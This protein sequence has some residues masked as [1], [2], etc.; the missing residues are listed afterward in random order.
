MSAQS[1]E[2]LTFREMHYT[3]RFTEYFVP[4]YFFL[5]R[6][7]SICI[8]DISFQGYE[9]LHNSFDKFITFHE[10]CIL[11][12]SLSF[13]SESRGDSTMT[14]DSHAA[15][16]LH[17]IEAVLSSPGD[18]EPGARVCGVEERRFH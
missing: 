2:A 5:I 18:S 17:L 12:I 10:G 15:F 3:G 8:P 4:Q 13:V 9:L 16:V 14:D 6:C 11:L 7:I 1:T